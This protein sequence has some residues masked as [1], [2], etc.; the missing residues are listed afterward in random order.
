M[1][2]EVLEQF[3]TRLKSLPSGF[4][5]TYMCASVLDSGESQRLARQACPQE[6]QSLL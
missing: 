2:G 5:S 1:E 6:L 3:H 4:V